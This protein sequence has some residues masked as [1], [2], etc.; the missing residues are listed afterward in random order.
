[1]DMT[2][3]PIEG[4]SLLIARLPRF[5][6]I[7]ICL[8]SGLAASFAVFCI[9]G[10]LFLGILPS[11]LD[12]GETAKNWM[13]GLVLLMTAL[14]FVPPILLL[15]RQRKRSL[16]HVTDLHGRPAESFRLEGSVSE[17]QPVSRNANKKV[18]TEKVSQP[19]AS[20]PDVSQRA[21]D[22]TTAKPLVDHQ[23]RSEQNETNAGPEPAEISV[24]KWYYSK[25][26]RRLGPVPQ[27]VLLRLVKRGE[28]L[29]SGMVWRTGMH[30]WSRLIDSELAK[31][32]VADSP[33]P[34][35]AKETAN[36]Y[37]WALALAPLWGTVLHYLLAYAYISAKY[38]GETLF[39]PVLVQEVI[40]KTWFFGWMLNMG[41]AFLDDYALKA[42]GW[43]SKKLQSWLIILVPIYI[44][45][46]D[47]MLGA[48][49]A[50]FLI[51]I[52]AFIISLLPIW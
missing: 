39:T 11:L 43:R 4:R 12:F 42:A 46:R 49:M 6:F 13:V 9:S 19:F 41:I 44:Y 36:G 5:V 7:P 27:D 48:G 23:S 37:A 22:A 31:Y 30:D 8:L 45:K 2:R 10:V 14:G 20:T 16:S 40:Q 47:Q 18:E 15:S 25:D 32:I 26:G 35:S 33:P 24:S 50:R 52:A 34:L 28:L 29:P 1:M 21:V 17:F 3:T 51:W 38:G